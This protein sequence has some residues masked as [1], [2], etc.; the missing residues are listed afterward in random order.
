MI[1]AYRI[2]VSKESLRRHSDIKKDKIKGKTVSC[3]L[4]NIT[5][6]RIQL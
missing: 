4:K 2:K 6:A 3:H 1:I 5:R